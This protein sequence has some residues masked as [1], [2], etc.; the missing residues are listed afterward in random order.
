MEQTKDNIEKMPHQKQRRKIGVD[1]WVLVAV[2]GIIVALGATVSVFIPNTIE[3]FFWEARTKSAVHV[4]NE[5]SAQL[6]NTDITNWQDG[7]SQTNIAFFA[8]ES[9]THLADINAMKV[10]TN[11]GTLA[12][13]DL[14]KVQAGYKKPGIESE[15]AE[16]IK[17]NG[18][19]SSAGESTKQEL[20]K[21]SLLEVWTVVKDLNGQQIGFVEFYF[22]SSDIS[23]FIATIRY[24][25]W[26]SIFVILLI[27]V[28]LLRIVFRQQND[29]IVKQAHELSDI[30]EQSPIGIYA[31]DPRGMITSINYKMLSFLD[32]SD[33]KKIIG[34][35]VFSIRAILQADIKGDMEKILF[36]T[37]FEKEVRSV[38]EGGDVKYYH[39]RATPLFSEDNK[40]IE[41]I[42]FMVEDITDRKKLEKEVSA[43]T[44][45]LEAKVNERTSVLETK[46]AELEQF[47]RVTIGRELRMSELKEQIERMRIKLESMGVRMNS[48]SL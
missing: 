19:I 21:E 32:E 35:N 17:T 34:Q 44:K 11:D 39:Y 40:T 43:Y 41:Q 26:G 28:L 42:L 29:I 12:W 7:D 46:I 30:I 15:L 2:G 10:F 9:K 14:K 37:P 23:A 5:L 1:T 45:N 13:T 24:A 22:D 25:I 3:H 4:V 47:Q 20:G 6:K 27:I 18:A 16:V 38:K 48:E 33:P 31:T 8:N 36:G